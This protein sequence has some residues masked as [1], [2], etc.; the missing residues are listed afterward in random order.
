MSV[1]L[2]LCVVIVNLPKRFTTN[3]QRCVTLNL[4]DGGC[5]SPATVVTTPGMLQC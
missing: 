4:W 5:R 1:K 3:Y 2:E